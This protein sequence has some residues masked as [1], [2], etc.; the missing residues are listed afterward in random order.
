[1]WIIQKDIR[2][3]SDHLPSPLLLLR[4]KTIRQQKR[5]TGT[6]STNAEP[7]SRLLPALFQ[8]VFRGQKPTGWQPKKSQRQILNDRPPQRNNSIL[9]RL[10]VRGQLHWLCHFYTADRWLVHLSS[11]QGRSSHFSP[12]TEFQTR[13]PFWHRSMT[14]W[15]SHSSS[16]QSRAE[17]LL[18]SSHSARQKKKNKT[19]NTPNLCFVVCLASNLG[20]KSLA[21]HHWEAAHPWLTLVMTSFFFNEKMKTSKGLNAAV[22]THVNKAM[23]LYSSRNLYPSLQTP[24]SDIRYQIKPQSFKYV[25]RTPYTKRTLCYYSR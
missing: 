16:C 3:Q 12:S 23:F 15:I 13:S 18:S 9:L 7:Q 1:M 11:K 19:N 17:I 8:T 10:L 6:N 22:P 24:K 21:P 4:N 25:N 20:R 2:P 14:P 5:L